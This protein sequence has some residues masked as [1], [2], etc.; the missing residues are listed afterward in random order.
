MK[1]LFKIF[2]F[3][4]LLI[5]NGCC[6]N[7][8][9]VC[10]TDISNKTTNIE[11]LYGCQNSAINFQLN[12]ISTYKIIT[13]ETDYNNFVT[14]ICHPNIDFEHYNLIIGTIGS[15]KELITL[16]YNFYQSCENNIYKLNLNVKY[17]N[18]LN[19]QTFYYFNVLVPKSYF[20]EYLKLNISIT[21]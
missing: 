15:S 6:N 16:N 1:F 7:D 11:S 21:I 4:F 5:N 8:D 2:F 12:P 19:T 10:L 17:G 14:G 3:I 20:I 13:N 9:D 18:E